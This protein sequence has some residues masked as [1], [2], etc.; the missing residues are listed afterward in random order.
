MNPLDKVAAVRR[1]IPTDGLFAEKD[2]L[3]APG[4]F[5][6]DAR[7]GE[8]LHKLGHRL[9]LFVRACNELYRRSVAG[10]QPAWIADY[11]DRGKP[12]ELVELGR[13]QEFRDQI[14]LVIR[15][16]L[17]LT[18]DGFTIAEIDNVPGGIG[19]TS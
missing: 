12:R 1:S 16:D 19:L 2:W 10:R 13:R 6:I 3:V 18:D 11:L 15:P 7:L 5:E 17:V 8:Q 14:P 4:P 9:L